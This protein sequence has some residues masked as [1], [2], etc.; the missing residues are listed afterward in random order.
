VFAPALLG[1]WSV[2]EPSAQ[3]GESAVQIATAV[4]LFLA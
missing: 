2:C 1:S 4:D 3:L